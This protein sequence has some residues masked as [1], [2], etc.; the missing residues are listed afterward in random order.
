VKWVSAS[1]EL[2]ENFIACGGKRVVFAGTCAEYEWKEAIL[3]EATTPLLPATLYGICKNALQSVFTAATAKAGVSSAWGRVFFLYGPYESPTRLVPAVIL[4]MLKG[5]PAM[6][7]H[8]R[9]VRDFMHVED[10]ARAFVATL[11]SEFQGPINIA[12]GTPVPLRHVVDIIADVLR[13]PDLLRIGARPEAP[14]DP[15]RLVADVK[16]LRDVVG[17]KAKYSLETGLMSAIHWWERNIGEIAPPVSA[18]TPMPVEKPASE[19]QTSI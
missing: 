17:F 3:S 4:P 10:V 14:A 1:L 13:R 9:Q 12:S 2:L 19:I 16:N 15:A 5:E 11:D 18:P 8:C 7:S 6:L